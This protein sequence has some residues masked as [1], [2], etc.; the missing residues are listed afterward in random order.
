MKNSKII[1]ELVETAEEQAIKVSR[2]TSLMRALNENLC[3]L[4]CNLDV[5]NQDH[6]NAH[7]VWQSVTNAIDLSEVLLDG[8]EGDAGKLRETLGVLSMKLALGE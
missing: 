2:Y 8:H 1:S 5:I 4:G 3:D 7:K 6:P